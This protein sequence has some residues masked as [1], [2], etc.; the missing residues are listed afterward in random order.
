MKSI[1]TKD[2][3]AILASGI[4]LVISVI[5]MTRQNQILGISA[6]VIILILVT[7]YLFAKQAR[8]VFIYLLGTAMVLLLAYTVWNWPV[9]L[10]VNL[11][12]DENNTGKRENFER[13]VG[14]AFE[15]TLLDRYNR[16]SKGYTSDDGIAKFEDVP[17]GEYS[18][19]L[20]E[21][22]K[23]GSDANRMNNKI[24]IAVTTTPTSTATPTSTPTATPTITPSPTPSNTPT[25]TPL[26]IADFA[27][28]DNINNL[29]GLMGGAFE[30]G[31]KIGI[32]YTDDSENEKEPCIA[33]LNYSIKTWSAFWI[34][35]DNTDVSQYTKLVFDVRGDTAANPS[36][37]KIEIKRDCATHNN[38]TICN[39]VS[40][41]RIVG[42]KTTWQTIVI[43]LNSFVTTGYATPIS[44]FWDLDELTVVFEIDHSEKS[45]IL[46]IDNIRFEQ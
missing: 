45:G 29:E 25:P 26:V 12:V 2:F 40:L 34:K 43:D 22:G 44:N 3:L 10:T 18:I 31:N 42:V 4:G 14:P 15:L 27:R 36:K 38:Q 11:Y 8:D 5:N 39:E 6:L 17:V 9:T 16:E 35:F 33:V 30:A 23:V 32:E 41:K 1:T 46:Y 13:S 7:G 28:C 37:F 20:P 24:Q 19:T 21:G